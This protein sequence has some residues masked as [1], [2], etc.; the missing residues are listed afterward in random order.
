[1]PK[2]KLFW[3][4]N[5]HCS[6]ERNKFKCKKVRRSFVFWK[7]RD[8]EKQLHE[9][10]KKAR[11]RGNKAKAYSSKTKKD[12]EKWI[13]T[14]KTTNQETLK[15]L[16]KGY[17]KKSTDN[18]YITLDT[19]HLEKRELSVLGSKSITLTLPHFLRRNNKIQTQ[20]KPTPVSP[21]NFF[22]KG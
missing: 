8:S 22:T 7:I 4:P 20:K 11:S 16:T 17:K 19:G 1:M 6:S 3:K 10:H 5:Q 13:F 12:T 9:R 2:S 21:I 14:S 18:H 15:N